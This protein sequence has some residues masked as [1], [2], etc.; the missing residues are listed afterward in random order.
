MIKGGDVTIDM[1]KMVIT[2]IDDQASNRKL[3]GHLQGPDF[4]D[5]MNHP[6]AG[7]SIA[8]VSED[9]IKANL[10]IKGITHPISIPYTMEINEGILT[11]H[12]VFE[13]DRAKYDVRYGSGSFFENLGDNLIE[14]MIKFEVDLVASIEANQ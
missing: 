7:F 5:V 10:T 12:A 3:Y 4:F 9:S 6:S 14:D 8:T 13:V 1:T 2:N 11:A